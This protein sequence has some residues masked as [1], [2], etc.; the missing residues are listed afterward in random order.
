M[1]GSLRSVQEELAVDK[2][3][4]SS[5]VDVDIN[6]TSS[7]INST[8]TSNLDENIEQEHETSN[9]EHETSLPMTTFRK[10]E[11]PK[12]EDKSPS[13]ASNTTE[14]SALLSPLKYSSDEDSLGGI[15][16]RSRSPLGSAYKRKNSQRREASDW[17]GSI[18]VYNQ[19]MGGAEEREGLGEGWKVSLGGGKNESFN[20]VW[21]GYGEDDEYAE[22]S[23][24]DDEL[25]VMGGGD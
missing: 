19:S 8:S 13:N 12:L 18:S 1:F 5:D 15:L 10:Y 20:E 22:M 6:S 24:L 9:I 25:G 21:E 7:N 11:P 16:D 17:K 14:H 2:V 23:D 3:V 4:D